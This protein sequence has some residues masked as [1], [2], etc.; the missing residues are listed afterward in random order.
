[1]HW[2]ASTARTDEWVEARS[3]KKGHENSWIFQFWIYKKMSIDKCLTINQKRKRSRKYKRRKV[4]LRMIAVI[5]CHKP[6]IVAK[7]LLTINFFR[8]AE[9]EIRRKKCKRS[10]ESLVKIFRSAQA[11]VVRGA[12]SNR[13][14]S[15]WPRADGRTEKPGNC[16]WGP[17]YFFWLTFLRDAKEFLHI[18]DGDERGRAREMWKRR[19]SW[20]LWSTGHTFAMTL[21]FSPR[22]TFLF[23]EKK[24]RVK[25][26]FTF[27]ARHIAS[28]FFPQPC[29]PHIPQFVAQFKPEFPQIISSYQT[30]KHKS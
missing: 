27:R 1:M 18:F 5:E 14:S 16:V 21:N 24:I 4:E 29:R 9:G 10:T 26:L 28:A 25:K 6:F 7:K 3:R 11:G 2:W 30:S 20:K 23:D 19:K 13:N 17:S 15:W 12:K 8:L 22:L